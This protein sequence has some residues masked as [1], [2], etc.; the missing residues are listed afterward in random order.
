MTG[1]RLSQ[2]DRQAI[3]AGLAA[4]RAYAEI[5]RQIGRPTSTVSREVARNGHREYAAD[6]AQRATRRAPRRRVAA[7]EADA[8]EDRKRAFV[9]ELAQ[10]LAATGMP[11]MASRVFAG[12]TVAETDATTAAALVSRLG[13]SPASVSKAIGYLEAMQLVERRTET[14]HRRE[15]YRVGDDIWTR[16]I[17]TDAS[18]HAGV[19]EAAQRGLDIFEADGPAGIRLARMSQF[20]STLTRQLR[21]SDLA[22]PTIDD[23]KT[24]IAALGHAQNALSTTQLADSLGWPADRL[25][26]ALRQLREHPALADP[27]AV[28]EG[29]DGYRMRARADRLSAGQRAALDDLAPARRLPT[30]RTPELAY[31]RSPAAISAP[32]RTADHDAMRLRNS[33][34]RPEP[35]TE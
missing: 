33:V 20:F 21:A 22:D 23:A 3:A 35:E 31:S 17:R 29:R 19:A 11:R 32:A 12:L 7:A 5:A 30:I 24:I 28:D 8:A 4:G 2:D 9:E 25:E 18:G 15:Q 26:A 34:V 13:V 10:V 1:G 6:Q 14:G 27:F 16:A